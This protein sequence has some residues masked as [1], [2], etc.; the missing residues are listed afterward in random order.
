MSDRQV[1]DAE[2]N[3]VNV[4]DPLGDKMTDE[5]KTAG[6]E[7]RIARIKVTSE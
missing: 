1:D 6:L 3:G 2:G 5:E 7:E 4:S